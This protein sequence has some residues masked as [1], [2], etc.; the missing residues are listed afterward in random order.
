MAAEDFTHDT[1]LLT[2]TVDGVVIDPDGFYVDC[3]FGRG[4]HTQEA[5]GRLSEKGRV[6]AI[7]KDPQAIAEG[8]KKFGSDPRFI[9]CHGSFAEIR[10]LVEREFGETKVT[11]VLMDLGVSSPQLDDQER[12][13]SFMR[14]GPLDMRMDNSKGQS[15]A[16]WLATAKEE[17]ITHV[18]KKLG[19]E[20]FGKRI[21]RKIVERR[22]Q[23]PIL[24]TLELAKLIDEAIPV[25]EKH[26]HPATRSFQAIRIYVNRELDDL[27]SCLDQAL[28]VLKP[29]GRLGVISFHSLEDRIVKRFIQKHEKGGDFPPDLPITADQMNKRMKRVGKPIKAS[30]AEV[31][32]NVRARSAILRIAEKLK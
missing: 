20:K 14:D 22:E 18:I 24:R 29:Q 25:K 8:Q 28:E 17:D 2:E 31:E 15:A 9:L 4:G 16:D 21:A 27:E 11:G 26:K 19:E 6:L 13:F 1:V 23:Q 7:D 12:G 5:L 3:T 32:G 30:A 10:E